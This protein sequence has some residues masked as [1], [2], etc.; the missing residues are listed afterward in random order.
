MV[1][2]Y[3][4]VLAAM[5]FPQKIFSGETTMLKTNEKK[6]VEFLLQCQPGPPKTRGI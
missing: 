2:L 1:S 6:I 5:P 4:T 3:G